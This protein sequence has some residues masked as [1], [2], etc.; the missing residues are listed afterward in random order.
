M[1]FREDVMI[2]Y[3][4]PYRYQ[5]SLAVFLMIAEVLVDLYQPRMM[6]S[7]VDEGI[8]GAGR[9]GVPDPEFVLRTGLAMALVVLLGGGCGIAGGI[10]V[11]F[12]AQHFGNDVRKACF[13]RILSF[14]MEQVDFFH[15][16]GLITRMTSDTAQVQT[17]V[18][19][20]LR[21][22][23]RSLTFLCVGT[24]ALLT[25]D[26][27][28]SLVTMLAIPVILL[29]VSV[30]V[31]K[32][33]PLFRLW[34]QKI[35]GLNQI[36]QED[37]RGA[38][39]IKG[40]H[41]EK[42]ENLRFG[43][44][45]EDLADTQL[46]VLMI[47]SCMLPLANIVMNAAIA[48]V[49]YVGALD[50]AS[51]RIMPGT[52][53]A[54]LTYIV[55]ILNG[56][57]MFAMILQ[58]FARGLTS[59]R[60]LQE[61][62]DQGNDVDGDGC[63]LPAGRNNA[64]YAVELRHVFF[65]YP[66]QQEDV[67]SDISLSVRPGEMLAVVGATGAGKSTLIRLLLRFYPATSG[68]I[69]VFDT[70]VRDYSVHELRR[71]ITVVLQRTDLFSLT[72]RD[73]I[74]WGCDD[75]SERSVREAARIAQAEAFILRQPEGYDTMVS[76]GGMSLSGGQRQR[77]AIARAVVRRPDILVFDDSTSALDMRTEAALFRDLDGYAQRRQAEGHPLTRIVVAQRIAT[78]R[79]AERIAVLDHGRLIG[80][81]THEELLTDC[82]L[83]QEICAS[84]SQTEEAVIPHG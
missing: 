19:T 71:K 29:E 43:V 37:I 34:Q 82:P 25:L 2:R 41:Q 83:Y 67:L 11:N 57:L 42:R 38:R 27:H 63:A 9:G 23:V 14:S 50:A 3:L 36:M 69:R 60:R 10:C 31:W 84:Q 28:F 33:N 32:S 58:L 48:A 17:M 51:G 68:S 5:A 13:R 47:I 56:L 46:R 22:V 64:A 8:L 6:A 45:N 55:Q 78:A 49:I 24:A 77:L 4:Y 79:H 40:Y 61:I 30:I 7:I 80:C 16:G 72:I 52:I 59:K 75:S 62:L 18:S 54:A 65:H 26:I 73:N 1:V 81:G 39:V 76:E 21:G 20:A 35:D 44:A 53:M 15:T 66:G 12:C 70:D 74:V